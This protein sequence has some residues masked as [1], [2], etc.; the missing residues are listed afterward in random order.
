MIFSFEKIHPLTQQEDKRIE[1]TTIKP[2]EPKKDIKGELTYEDKVIQKIIGIALEN[3]NGLLTVDGG[4][5][6]NIKDKLVNS[7]DVT[8]GISTEVGKQQVA[9][10]MDVVV[11]YGKDIEN[12]YDQMKKLISEEVNKM[13][14]L[15][16]IEVNVNVVDIKTRAEYEEDSETVQDKVTSAAQTTGRFASKQTNRAKSALSNQTDKI[17]DNLESEPRVK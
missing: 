15:D 6:S 10:D 4:F 3:V 8:S 16:V 7:D 2:T 11:E 12:I 13:T 17:S 5:F 14:H 1:N 9:V